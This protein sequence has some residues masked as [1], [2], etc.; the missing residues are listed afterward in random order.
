MSN[1]QKALNKPGRRANSA[2]VMGAI[3]GDEGKGRITD[4]LTSYFLKKF[5]KVVVY[6][7]NGGANA[8]HTISM[9]G[10]KIGL[11]QI[12]SG[13]LQK[14]CVVVLGKGMVIHP[15][16]LLEEIKEIKK[17]FEFKQLPAKLMIDEMAVLNLD[18]HRAFEMALKE[19]KGSSLGSKAAT[20]RG[21]APSYADVL[22]R[23]PLR[24]RDLYRENWKELFKEHYQRYNSWIKGMG[25]DMKEITVRRFG[26]GEMVIGSERIFLKNIEA[27]RDELKQYVYQ[28]YEYIK[29]EWES[30]TPFI[31]EKAQA[32]GL[33]QRWALYPDCSA[34]NCCI[35]GITASTEGIVNYRDIS[36]KFGVIKSTYTS[37]VGKRKLP[38][39]MEEEYAQVIRDDAYE[40]GTTTGRPRDIAY[41]DLVMLKYFCKVSDIEELVFTHMDV[42]YDN[43]VKVC[44][45]YMKGNKESY[46]R[47][48][49]EFLNDI[50]PV[51]KSL[52][53][54]K[55]EE[56]KEVKKYDYTQKEARDFVDYISEFTNTTPVMITFGPDRD[57]T[58]II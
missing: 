37:S 27:I 50:L 48:D 2:V 28:M 56:L 42:V 3:L 44:I 14:G 33:D 19:G 35:D 52:K 25:I 29:K 17:V 24:L 36:G 5:N 53:P 45:K 23:F 40:Y 46:Y 21:I 4:E 6:R 15:I 20:G 38:T 18:T 22:Y 51:Y 26:K 54:W 34:S 49:Q 10:K 13:I 39:M 9:N 41:M 7:D 58:I 16:D 31:F 11:H 32:V 30:D 57:D 1:L 12:G 55:K 43:P 47:P 8:G